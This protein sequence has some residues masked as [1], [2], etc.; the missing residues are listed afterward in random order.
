MSSPW[1]EV[2]SDFTGCLLWYSMCATSFV[3]WY[4][5]SRS[6]LAFCLSGKG[7]VLK[8]FFSTFSF[9]EDLISLCW[10]KFGCTKN[11]RDFANCLPTVAFSSEGQLL[12]VAQPSFGSGFCS[13]AVSWTEVEPLPR[14]LQIRSTSSHGAFLVGHPGRLSWWGCMDKVIA[15]LLIL[16]LDV[17]PDVPAQQVV[18]GWDGMFGLCAVVLTGCLML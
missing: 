3:G 12:G 10:C 5:Q 4:V 17:L 14:V 13:A 1:G 8:L 11:T 15:Q 9:T 7:G 6:V 18:L 2:R 16:G